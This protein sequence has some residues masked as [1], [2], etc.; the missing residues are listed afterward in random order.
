M[1]AKTLRL[2]T[3]SSSIQNAVNRPIEEKQRVRYKRY[4]LESYQPNSTFY[5]TE[6]ERKHLNRLGSAGVNG[7]SDTLAKKILDRFLLDLSWNS[8]RLEGSTY[9]L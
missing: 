2:S 3:R 8:S 5:L 4:F 9:S 6:G 1:C 7:L